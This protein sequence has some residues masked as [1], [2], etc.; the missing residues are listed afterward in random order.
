LSTQAS[1]L[2]VTVTVQDT[3]PGIPPEDIPKLFQSFQQLGDERVRKGGSGLGLVISK[4]IIEHHQGKIWVES[5]VGEGTRFMFALPKHDIEEILFEIIE[6]TGSTLKEG[7]VFDLYC[8]R[9][10]NYEQIKKDH[11]NEQGQNMM[12]RI[13]ASLE[14]A[15]GLKEFVSK[16][17]DDEIIVFAETNREHLVDLRRRMRAAVKETI[18]DSRQEIKVE[19]SHA[20]VAY[21]DDGSQI[22]E[23][24]DLCEHSLI[25]DHQARL[26]KNIL[27]VDDEAEVVNTLRK[28]LEKFGYSDIREAYDGEEALSKLMAEPADLVILDMKM[29]KMSGYELI[30]R[31]KG[32]VRLQSIPLLI[33]SGYEVKTDKL[34]EF[35]Q[36]E[37][38]PMINKPFSMDQLERWLTYLL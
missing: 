9:V 16:R 34:R 15:V 19:F 29:P 12:K 32:D 21:P 6:R 20:D 7:Q 14:K 28:M 2:T 31:I 10:D 27:V 17:G 13:A 5:K 1:G 25:N 26:K 11:G 3:G 23:L 37:A 24:L 35:N 8:M 36:K 22:R 38:I 4:E 30:G 33:I 18:F